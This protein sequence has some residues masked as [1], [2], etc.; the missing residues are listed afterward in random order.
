[1]Q[2]CGQTIGRAGRHGGQWGFTLVEL[3]ITLGII[4]VI[5]A[6]GYPNYAKY[7]IRASR[8]AAQGELIQL[9]NMQEK[10][11]LNSNSYTPSVTIAYNGTSAGGLG[12]TS[13][14]TSDNK[15]TLSV[16]P[17]VASQTFTLTATPVA[18][19]TQVGDGNITIDSSGIKTW[20]VTTW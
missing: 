12:R 7:T 17:N 5:A 20:G 8:Q 15:Y 13:G 19:T 1:M 18:G 6:I 3:M 4:A 10:I 16:S 9:A 11:F 2:I 14:K